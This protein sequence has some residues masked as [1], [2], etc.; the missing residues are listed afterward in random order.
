MSLVRILLVFL[1][2]GSPCLAA[3][4]EVPLTVRETAGVGRHQWPIRAGVPLPKGAVKSVE[5][6]Q[7]LDAHGRFVPALFVVAAVLG[8]L[9][10]RALT[11]RFT[12]NAA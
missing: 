3:G 9:S 2:L 12:T 10:P 4:I 7:I 11:L 6:L 1:V 8:W 5:K